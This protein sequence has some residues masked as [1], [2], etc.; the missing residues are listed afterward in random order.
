MKEFY[1]FPGAHKTAT[2]LLQAALHAQAERLAPAG[3]EVI[4][5]DI[6]YSSPLF[7]YMKSLRPQAKT[8]DPDLRKKARRWAR[9]IRSRTRNSKLVLS[10]ESFFGEPNSQPYPGVESALKILDEFFPRRKIR[11]TYYVRRQDT[12]FESVYIQR[13]QKGGLPNFDKFYRSM[14]RAD[15]DWCSMLGTMAEIVGKQNILVKPFEMIYWGTAEYVRDFFS[16]FVQDES[17]LEQ[18]SILP[19]AAKTNVSLSQHA[20]DEAVR[21][22][23]DLDA[24]GRKNLIRRLQREASTNKYARAELLSE[25]RRKQVAEKYAVANERLFSKWRLDERLRPYYTFADATPPIAL[26]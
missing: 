24:E 3:I 4:S 25:A 8:N 16:S 15:Y 10:G 12:F 11:I 19:S 23:P 21:K 26:V 6:F 7:A 14:Y 18:V 22:F 13:I 1:L 20:L 5:R 9:E 17:L 2:T